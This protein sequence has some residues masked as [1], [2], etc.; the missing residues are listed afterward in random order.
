MGVEINDIKSIYPKN[1]IEGVL[2]WING[3]DGLLKYVN[4]QKALDYISV[5]LTNLT[6]NGNDAKGST[7]IHNKISDAK[8]K[9]KNLQF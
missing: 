3:N 6:G 7:N 8:I 2:D 1:H 9:N 5:Q 4:K